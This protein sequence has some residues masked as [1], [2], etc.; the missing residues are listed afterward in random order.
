MTRN[1]RN[2]TLLNH[3]KGAQKARGKMLS[4]CSSSPSPWK[5]ETNN[6]RWWGH[7]ASNE[8]G[9]DSSLMTWCTNC[10]DKG[11]VPLYDGMI[12]SEKGVQIGHWAML[13]KLSHLDEGNETQNLTK[14]F[15][16]RMAMIVFC[17][18]ICI[19]KNCTHKSLLVGR[20]FLI[21]Q[22]S[23]SCWLLAEKGS[24]S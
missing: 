21:R 15:C 1:E 18:M 3:I 13:C 2:I 17:V 19:P 9:H 7:V 24:H 4:N 11:M 20:M 22:E 5:W 16:Y 23:S 14:W 12:P 6:K 8:Y 10:Y